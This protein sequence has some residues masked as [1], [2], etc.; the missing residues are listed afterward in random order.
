MD[1]LKKQALAYLSQHIADFRY[2]VNWSLAADISGC[3]IDWDNHPRLTRAQFFHDNDYP[4]AIYRFLTDVYQK[5]V[6]CLKAIVGYIYHD[7]GIPDDP[8]LRRSLVVLGIVKADTIP[9]LSSLELSVPTRFIDVDIFPDD[10]YR[11]LVHLI[12]EAYQVEIFAVI[13]ILI[14]RLLE[15][16]L[17]D[18]L[19][20]YYGMKDVSVFYDAEHGKF[21]DFSVLMR[22]M[23]ERLGDFDWC[24]DLLNEKLLDGINK[25][26]EAGNASA[27]SMIVRVTPEDLAKGKDEITHVVKQLFKTL[28]TMTAATKTAQTTDRSM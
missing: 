28:L 12:N 20:S 22:K 17:I 21:H 25:Y 8:T 4:E 13:P 19:R 27:H 6:E 24:V 5:G 1:P 9:S 10:F 3:E 14:R 26:R 23:K 7:I 2:G 18:I 16:L 15:N 11:D